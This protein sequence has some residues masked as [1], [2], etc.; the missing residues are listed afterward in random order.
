[1]SRLR[2]LKE[3]RKNR[4]KAT[5]CGLAL[6]LVMGSAQGLGTYA[7][8]TDVEDV[9]SDIA[10]STG[11]V[12]VEVSTD[13]HFT[14]VQPGK[15]IK[16][17]V[18]IT[19]NG[20]LN[21]NIKLDLDISDAI[22]SNLTHNFKFDDVT[23]NEDL[24]MYNDAGLFVLAPGGSI[25]GSINITVDKSMSN[26]LQNSLAGKVQNVNLTVKSTQV[27][28][29]KTL[30]NNGFYD[31]AIQKNTI[32]LAQREIITIATGEKAYVT[33]GN[34][35][36]FKKLYVPVNVKGT[37]NEFEL[38]ATVSSKTGEIEYNATHYKDAVYGDYILIQPKKANGS[39]EFK[40]VVNITITVTVKKD[41]NII[42]SYDL[43]CNTTLK[44]AGNDCTGGHPDH[45]V[46]GKCHGEIVYDGHETT[47]SIP[48]EGE[49]EQELPEVT[50]PVE[51]ENQP[52]QDLELPDVGQKPEE[53]VDKPQAPEEIPEEV[54]PPK[55][56]VVI[57][58]QPEIIPPSKE[59]I[60]IEE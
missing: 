33:G 6:A 28:K 39:I 7:L 53:D 48:E 40:G 5:S 17:P 54:E 34:G 30:V 52:P 25:T 16:M 47:L 31:V 26:E 14:D 44:N 18:T 2:R 51:G 24:V 15:E 13:N 20:T 43:E 22:E 32:S 29:D 27:N 60:E 21:Q 8:F 59:D 42:E 57:P 9:P 45:G 37:D 10:L 19:N 1:M 41:G 46:G 55:E 3:R 36:S 56:E 38:S 50:P 4:I 12:D 49:S 23:L 35:N 58:S 11:D